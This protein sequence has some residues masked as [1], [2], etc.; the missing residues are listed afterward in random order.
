FETDTFYRLCDEMGL[1]VWQ[2][3]LF[4]CAA[5]PEEAP[6]DKLVAEEARQHVTRLSKNPSLVLW[7]GNNENIWGYFDWGWKPKIGDRTWGKG[8]Y[9]DVLPKICAE[10]DPSRPYWGGSPFSGLM[11]IPPNADEHGNKHV[12]DAWNSADY[13]VYRKYSPRFCSEFGHCGPATYST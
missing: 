10:I 6:F 9:L 2:D 5:Y 3:F 11:D 4:A 12:W 1:M 13:L 8:F 7:N